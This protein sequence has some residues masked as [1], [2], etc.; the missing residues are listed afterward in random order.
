MNIYIYMSVRVGWGIGVFVY[1][2]HCIFVYKTQFI[3]LCV[4][5]SCNLCCCACCGT[6]CGVCCSV[7]CSVHFRNIGACGNSMTNCPN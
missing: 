6:C 7:C 3:L 4:A 5:G 2:T 1:E